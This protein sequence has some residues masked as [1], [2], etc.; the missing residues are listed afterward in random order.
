[1]QTPSAGPEEKWSAATAVNAFGLKMVTDVAA[2]RPQKNVFLSPLSVFAALAMTESGAAGQTRTAMRQAMAVPASI[3]EDALQESASALL[4]SL[5]SRK[6]VELLIANALW[7]DA[8][9]PLAPRFVQ[10]CLSLYQ[11]D[12][13]T[14]DFSEP[15]AADAINAWVKRNTQGK[16]PSIVTVS[17]VRNSA[18]IIT[19]AVY[20]KAGWMFRFPKNQTQ[21]GTFHL[22]NSKEKKVPFMHR[23]A[24]PGAYRSG[25]GFEAAALPYGSSR[26]QS[27]QI[28]LYAVLPAA[29]KSPEEVLAKIM[30][31]ELVVASQRNVLELLDLRLPRFTLDFSAGLR[32]PLEQMG[33]S[34][35]F[36]READFS[37]MGSPKFYI[38]EV[39]HKTRLEVDEEGTVAAAVTAVVT[40]AAKP[41]KPQPVERKTLVFDR[42]FGLLLCDTQT[43][44]VLF[45]GVIYDPH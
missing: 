22:V 11:A 9:L 42:P 16:I 40:A 32:G 45:A 4:K 8:E 38:N 31:K 35:A 29:G 33:M 1:M 39:L 17:D 3:S 20:F 7:A 13:T 30:V 12:A 23:S 27:S 44:A 18:T 34:V 19:N 2:Q 41:E 14:L 36:G 5:R 6:G 25:N 37:P 28:A 15:T 10:Q 21:D 24:I 43:G 26:Y